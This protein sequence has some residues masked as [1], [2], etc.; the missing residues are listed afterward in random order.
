MLNQE[1]SLSQLSW[2]I[3]RE[4]IN[5]NLKLLSDR[6]LNIF[7]Q[8]FI[9][10]QKRHLVRYTVWTRTRYF[11]HKHKD[12]INTSDVLLN[13]GQIVTQYSGFDSFS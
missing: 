12:L 9:M 6:V 1:L 3:I 13:F 8:L 4:D 10:M 2:Q 5:I 7:I 11:F